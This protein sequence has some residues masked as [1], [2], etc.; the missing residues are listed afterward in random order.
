MFTVVLDSNPQP[1][2]GWVDGFLTD[3]THKRD[4][5]NLWRTTWEGGVAGLRGPGFLS[6]W[7]VPVLPPVSV[8]I[9]PPVRPVTPSFCCCTPN[10]G[11][12]LCFLLLL[13]FMSFCF[14]LLF[15]FCL[16]PRWLAWVSCRLCCVVFDS[17]LGAWLS[18]TQLR[19]PTVF[20][21]SVSINIITACSRHHW[22]FY[23]NVQQKLTPTQRK[24]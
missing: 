3:I 19:G 15:Y 20:L 1:P 18:L 4:G 16:S 24:C 8:E 11:E 5:S 7:P 9:V 6:T 23:C 21:K 2:L 22:I 10:H 14:I 12:L 13:F 17:S